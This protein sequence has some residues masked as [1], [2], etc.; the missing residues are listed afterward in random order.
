MARSMNS[1]ISTTEPLLDAYLFVHS[2]ANK[3][4]ADERLS[5]LHVIT[6]VNDAFDYV[7]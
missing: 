4:E 1:S 6:S 3:D 5:R 7:F 2:N